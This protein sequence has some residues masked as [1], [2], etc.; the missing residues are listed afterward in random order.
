MTRPGKSRSAVKPE[1]PAAQLD[2]ARGE[3]QDQHNDKFRVLCESAPLGIFECDQSGEVTYHNR[4]LL[5]L[6]GLGPDVHVREAWAQGIHPDDLPAMVADWQNTVK[7]GKQWQYD[8]R[9]QTPHKGMRWMRVLLTPT[10]CDAS[11]RP[12][13]FVGTVEDIT[14]R[15]AAEATLQASHDELEAHVAR[16][17]RELSLAN[18][19]LLQEAADRRHSEESLRD[20]ETRF[21]QLA[22]NI[23]EVFWVSA[24]DPRRVLYVSPAYAKIWGRSCE[25]LCEDFQSFLDSMHPDDRQRMQ[26][27]LPRARLGGYDEIYRIVRPDGSVRTIRSRAFPVRDD[28]GTVYRI[29]GIAQDITESKLVEEELLAEQR[30][31]EHLLQVQ[32]GERKLV[33]YDIHDGFVQA[34]IAAGMHLEGLGVDPDVRESTR[35]KLEVP[36]RLLRECAEEARRMISGL[37]PPII[38]EQGLVAA[39]E[40]LINEAPTRAAKVEFHHD[41]SFGRL[42]GVLEG[43]LFRIV[44][45]ALTNVERHSQSK[46]AQVTL[47]QRGDRLSLVVEDWGIG[48]DPQNIPHRKFGLRGIRERARLFGG[49]AVIES[50]PGRGTRISVEV[51]LKSPFGHLPH[52]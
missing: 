17:T 42:D 19:L 27:S 9:M 26:E 10:A 15:K 18:E 48:F 24:I 34:V 47:S 7:Q 50:T 1:R 32:E 52:G 49:A 38:D 51:P 41:V 28:Q 22:E 8:Y 23:D 6:A 25:S 44:Q 45:E 40:Y 11:G 12:V 3:Q 29:A 2:G 20:S 35:K 13:S 43:T 14:D 4:Q 37:R 46:V 21:R 33:A 36:L 16:R 31:L 30:F 5:E 39:I